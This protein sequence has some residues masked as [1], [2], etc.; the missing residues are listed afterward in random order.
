MSD[1]T[2]ARIAKM[3]HAFDCEDRAEEE[4]TEA[5]YAEWWEGGSA[6]KA[7][8]YAQADQL[9]E[10]LQREDPEPLECER[11]TSLHDHFEL[12]EEP[13]QVVHAH[14]ADHPGAFC[15][16]C[17]NLGAHPWH[18]DAPSVSGLQEIQKYLATMGFRMVRE[19]P[20][21]GRDVRAM[22]VLAAIR[23]YGSDTLS[24][25]AD[26]HPVDV[27]WLREGIREMLRRADSIL[28][29]E[30]DG[31]KCPVCKRPMPIDGSRVGDCCTDTCYVLG[32]ENRT[33]EQEGG[34]G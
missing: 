7:H 17:G 9:L 3:L 33:S 14:M 19:P 27:E 23:L 1:E 31:E 26:G 8:Y 11:C 16:V 25:R 34:A 24:G 6:D 29:D 5:L 21:A 18:E 2:R 22:E 32:Q 12:A 13:S 15:L 30:S 28:G 4:D 20:P 10:V